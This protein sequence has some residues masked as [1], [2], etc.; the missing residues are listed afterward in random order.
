[1][2]Q[3]M[4]DILFTLRIPYSLP[5]SIDQFKPKMSSATLCF[6][7]SPCGVIIICYKLISTIITYTC[8]I[9]YIYIYI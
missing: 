7:T 4:T 6:A 8:I 2:P 5:I 1:M 9:V 3:R